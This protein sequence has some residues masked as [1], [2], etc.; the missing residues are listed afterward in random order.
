MEAIGTVAVIALT[1]ALT[2]T[3][4]PPRAATA[5][6]AA[7]AGVLPAT[8]TDATVHMPLGRG[9]RAE[10]HV[11]GGFRGASELH[12]ALLKPNGTLFQARRVRLTASE[13]AR[14]INPVPVRLRQLSGLWQGRFRFPLP[15]T[16]KLTLTVEDK[17]YGAVVTT[18]EVPISPQ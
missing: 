1:S 4:P 17:S 10:L 15:G 14:D 7:G 11:T 9:R 5:A 2:L 3:S 12:L 16:W 6:A 13:P 18:G 8:P